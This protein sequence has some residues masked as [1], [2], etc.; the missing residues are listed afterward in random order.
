MLKNM[1]SFNNPHPFGVG[2]QDFYIISVSKCPLFKSSI[3]GI[4]QKKKKKK[5]QLLF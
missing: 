2:I 5:S 1:L 4:F 3:P